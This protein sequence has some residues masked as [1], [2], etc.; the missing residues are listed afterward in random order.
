MFAWE[1]S[2]HGYYFFRWLKHQPGNSNGFYMG[3]SIN[4]G[5]PLNHPFR[6]MGCSHL[7]HP[8]E[9]PPFTENCHLYKV[10]PP[11]LS[12]LV[13]NPHEYYR[14][15]T[16]NHQPKRKKVLINQLNANELGHHRSR[17]LPEKKK[18]L[19]SA[20]SSKSDSEDSSTPLMGAWWIP[21]A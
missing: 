7:H 13:Y 6:T 8:F 4:G 14:Y 18:P 16:S 9:L 12:L 3:V 2:P 5:K 1:Q 21:S 19:K 15:I 10:L 11:Q 20:K 17:F